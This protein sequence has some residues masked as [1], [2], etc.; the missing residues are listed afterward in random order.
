MARLP[1]VFATYSIFY[2]RVNC[3][4]SNINVRQ[5][6][7]PSLSVERSRYDESRA[8]VGRND[9]TA[10]SS[11]DIIN[12]VEFLMSV[13]EFARWDIILSRVRVIIDGVWDWWLDLLHILTQRVTTLHILHYRCLVAVFNGESSPSSVFLN[14][15]WPQPPA[16]H[17]NIS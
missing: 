10:I 17:S 16:S 4:G 6:P 7:R 14:C 3:R 1:T 8:Q 13:L 5:R 15:S 11:R 2:M 12:I 9:F